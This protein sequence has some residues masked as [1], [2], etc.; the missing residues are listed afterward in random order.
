[1]KLVSFQ[2]DTPLG[3]IQRLGVL[4]GDVIDINAATRARFIDEGLSE[5]AADRLANALTPPRI[6]EFIEAGQHARDA[7]EETLRRDTA[8][9]FRHDIAALTLLPAVTGT[10]MLRDFLSFEGHLRNVY[11]RL[12]RQIPPE[13]YELPAYYKGN[14]ASLGAHED[15]ITMPPYAEDLDF[16]FE[17]A[18]VI[19]RGGSDIPTG[20]AMEHI[21]GYTIYDDFSA[22]RIQAKEMAV[23]LGPAKSKDFHHAHV[24]GP[25]LVTADEIGDPYSLRMRA[26]VNDEEWVDDTSSDMHWRFDQMIAYASTA[27]LIRPGEIFGS[28]TV[29]GGSAIERGGA[30]KRGDTVTLEISGLG[31]LRNTIG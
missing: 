3:P 9:R 12:G 24:L 28:G 21:Y 19:G 27:E 16:E 4:D 7:A 5:S 30:L 17:F 18:A 22:R 1:M 2:L 29:A 11:P 13:W 6:V 15:V 8:E 14:T 25:Y 23:G 10:P 31:R 26:W 20:R